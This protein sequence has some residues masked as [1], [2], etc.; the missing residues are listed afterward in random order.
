M[1]FTI[2]RRLGAVRTLLLVLASATV[3]AC[4]GGGGGSST[5][6]GAFTLAAGS[7]TF[8]VLRNSPLPASQSVALT[9]TG[10][11]VTF[12]G[13]AYENGQGQPGWLGIDITGSGRNYSLVVRVLDTSLPAGDYS[14]T[15]SVGTADSAGNVL[16]KRTFTVNYTVT[17]GIELAATPAQASF[18]FG[19]TRSTETLGLAVQ[20]PGRQW[21]LSANAAWLTVPGGAQSGNASVQLTVDAGSLAPGNYLATVTATNSSNAADTASAV[22]SVTVIPASLDVVQD[23]VLLGGAD[24]RSDVLRQDVSFSVATGNGTHPYTVSLQTDDGGDWLSVD[25]AAGTVGSAGRSVAVSAS[26]DGLAGGTRTAQLRVSVDVKG[27]VFTEVLPVTFNTEASRLVTTAAGVG[28]SSAP[29]RAVLTRGVKVLSSLGLD[30]VPWTAASNQSWLAVTPS[31]VTGGEVV[32][33]ADPAGLAPGATYFANVTVSSP[34][35]RVENEQEI[36]VGLHVAAAAPVSATVEAATAFLAA[37]PVEPLVATSDGAGRSVQLRDVNTGA[38]LRT[39]D[40]VAAQAGAVAFSGDGRMLFVHDVINQEVVAVSPLTGQ[41]LARFDATSAVPGGSVGRALAY[42]RPAGYPMLVTPGSRVFDVATGEEWSDPDFGIAGSAV[43][44]A[45]SPDQ[46]LVVPDFGA[47]K[48]LER[49]ALNGGS[50]VVSDGVGLSTPQGRAGEACVAAAGDRAYT[51]SGFPYDFPATDLA[52]GAVVQRL[53]GSAYPNAIQCVWNGLVVGGIDGFYDATDIWVYDGPTGVSLAQLSSST[54]SGNRSLV[55]RGL[56][57][58]ADGTRLVSV[59]LESGAAAARLY[60][61][62]LP[63]AP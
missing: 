63:S 56:A 14:S 7:A 52:T 27:T 12:V 1:R 49:S 45:V 3:A 46:S 59:A 21:T 31:G 62:N 18:I 5:P 38:L 16:Q 47:V 36:R 41:V 2:G 9:V 4:G 33:T 34:D 53:P 60:F 28:L 25:S 48:R 22:V 20:A 57:V 55:D 29:G 32:L 42:L 43:S 54:A 11:N 35:P 10:D 51:A 17:P 37:S 26:R 23:D 6:A 24:G 19:D 40:D 15:F 39:L 50:L 44:L 58:S 61:Q 30:D 8:S 13:A